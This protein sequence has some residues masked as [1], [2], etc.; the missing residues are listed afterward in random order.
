MGRLWQLRKTLPAHLKAF[1][2]HS[3]VEFVLLDYNSRDGLEQWILGN[4]IARQAI[5]D[6]LLVYAKEHTADVYHSSKA[7]NLAHRL[8]K[9]EILVNLDADNWAMDIDQPLRR[10]FRR[11]RD[12]VFQARNR[13]RDGSGGRIALA[14]YWFFQLGG[15]NEALEPIGYQDVDMVH[16][17]RAAS[18]RK[19]TFLDG[20]RPLRNNIRQK[21]ALCGSRRALLS[22][23]RA[24]SKM[25]ASS[26]R[27]GEL[28][29][30][31]HGWGAGLV[32]INF[33]SAFNLHPV[34]FWQ[35]RP[36][37]ASHV[38][39]ALYRRKESPDVGLLGRFRYIRSSKPD[40][41][42]NADYA[43]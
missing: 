1:D 24:N 12:I 20:C 19:R 33:G 18:L 29:A 13:R 37:T 7:K 6:G 2:G 17:A 9:G 5:D 35:A 4:P 10:A 34:L 28:S 32:S 40:A 39:R 26:I 15:Y 27:R 25:S 30:N 21:T 36:D 31:P 22:M 3:D 42:T 14:R 11:S 8:A 16:R 41:R 38:V 23:L 43:A